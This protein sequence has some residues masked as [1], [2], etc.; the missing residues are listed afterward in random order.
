[1]ASAQESRFKA[2]ASRVDPISR[3]LDTIVD[4]APPDLLG[5]SGTKWTQLRDGIA[6]A[7][8][9]RSLDQLQATLDRLGK[10]GPVA[11]L[12]QRLSPALAPMAQSG[13][14]AADIA[15]ALIEFH[16]TL[17]PE[18]A[19]RWALRVLGLPFRAELLDPV[20]DDAFATALIKSSPIA[21]RIVE[22]VRIDDDN[23]L[24]SAT[25]LVSSVLTDD[26][27][28]TL[29]E[30]LDGKVS[31]ADIA[32]MV[33]QLQKRA[34]EQQLERDIPAEKVAVF[35][36]LK[37]LF[38]SL[39]RVRATDEGQQA[40]DVLLG[41]VRRARSIGVSIADLLSPEH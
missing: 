25:H 14:T 35:G 4:F 3:A 18:V 23:A 26:A 36:G 17:A 10:E 1:L 28:A 41:I 7:I 20:I 15:R 39:D 21:M 34:V 5:D 13:Q 22:T 2:V 29:T 6:A 38:D 11:A 16:V 27:V 33:E 9:S 37:A 32:T 8:S 40:L 31:P 12:L 19:Q 30:E 24:I